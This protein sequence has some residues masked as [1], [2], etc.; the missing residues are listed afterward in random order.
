[1]T[2]RRPNFDWLLTDRRHLR[3]NLRDVELVIKR[4]QLDGPGEGMQCRRDSLVLAVLTIADYPDLTER[5]HRRVNDVLI[6]IL[7]KDTAE[8]T[9]E[10]AALKKARQESNREDWRKNAGRRYWERRFREAGNRP[11]PQKPRIILP[12]ESTSWIQ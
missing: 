10:L 12:S 2:D 8:Q 6:Q 11:Q 1:M 9:A 7:W 5:E 4:G 3:G